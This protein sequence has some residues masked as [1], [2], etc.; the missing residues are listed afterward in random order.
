MTERSGIIQPVLLQ[1]NSVLVEK[2]RRQ[3]NLTTQMFSWCYCTFSELAFLILTTELLFHLFYRWGRW[4]L[5]RFSNLLK[6]TH[7]VRDRVRTWTQISLMPNTASITSLEITGGK[8]PTAYTQCGP[9]GCG[10]SHPVTAVSSLLLPGLP[11]PL[12]SKASHSWGTLPEHYTPSFPPELCIA[13]AY[14]SLHRVMKEHFKKRNFY[15]L[16]E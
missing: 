3:K 8:T 14:M 2:F 10:S 13:P 6:Y 5:G 9:C 1:K 16:D 4:G 7:L 11:V 15:L 12:L